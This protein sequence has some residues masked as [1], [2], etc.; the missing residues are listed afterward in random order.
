MGELKY[1]RWTQ[2]DA[3]KRVDG[4]Q[5]SIQRVQGDLQMF[6]ARAMTLL[7]KTGAGCV[8]YGIKCYD[9]ANMLNEV[10]FCLQPVMDVERFKGIVAGMKNATVYA[11][12][13]TE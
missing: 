13:K 10:K 12:Y 4:G 5:I 6:K 1:V 11:V 7:A 8:V 9:A 3:G 2:W